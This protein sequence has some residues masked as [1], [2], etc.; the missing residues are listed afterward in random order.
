MLFMSCLPVKENRN[1][2][3]NDSNLPLEPISFKNES[4]M[5]ILEKSSCFYNVFFMI[6]ILKNVI[7]KLTG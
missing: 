6:F 5:R 2:H 1:G 3:R 4:N 7:R